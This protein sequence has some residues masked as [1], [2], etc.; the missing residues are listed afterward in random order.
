MKENRYYNRFN[1]VCKW[2]ILNIASAEEKV[3]S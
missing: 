2:D 1:S 3:I